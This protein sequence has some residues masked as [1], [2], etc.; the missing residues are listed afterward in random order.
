ML[1]GERRDEIAARGRNRRGGEHG[2]ADLENW[3][4]LTRLRI[5]PADATR[6]LRALLVLTN[7]EVTC[8]QMITR[9]GRRPLSARAPPAPTHARPTTCEWRMERGPVRLRSAEGELRRRPGLRRAS[10]PASLQSPSPVEPRRRHPASGRPPALKRVS[11]GAIIDVQVRLPLQ[12][13]ESIIVQSPLANELGRVRLLPARPVPASWQPV[14]VRPDLRPSHACAAVP[15][16]PGPCGR[17]HLLRPT[18]PTF[19]TSGAGK[20]QGSGRH[21]PTGTTPGSTSSRL[22]K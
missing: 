18:A 11:G 13:E 5:N 8:W 1:G 6:L 9:Y 17:L 4:I 2:F 3:P 14:P 12:A 19:G 20:G 15:I 22:L 16:L 21:S 7:L 10:E